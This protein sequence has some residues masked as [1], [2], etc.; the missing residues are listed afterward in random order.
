ME[1]GAGQ[2]VFMPGKLGPLT[3]R[4]R[5]IK[6]ATYE[7]MSPGGVPSDALVAHHR[8][9]AAGGTAMTTVAYCA[10]SPDARTFGE[11]M[12]IHEGI[13]P[14]LRTLT[15]AVHREGAAA[16]LQLAHCGF[17]TK[18][19][20]RTV[21]HALGPSVTL[22]AYGLFKGLGLV[23]PMTESDMAL[24]SED[25]ARAALLAVE[26][27]FDAVELHLGHGYLLSQFL[28]P[29]TNRRRDAWGG[30]LE[31]RL[32]LPVDVARRVHDRVGSRAAILA[33]VNLRDGFRGGLELADAVEI[34]RRLEV[35]GVDA[36]VLSGGFTS[37]TPFYLLRGGRPLR[38]MIAVEKSRIQKLAIALFGPLFMKKYPFTEMF[39]LDDARAVRGAV[40][41]PLVLLGGIVSRDNLETAMREGFDFVALGRAL[42]HDPYLVAKLAR[43]EVERSGCNHCNECV[44][45]MDRGGVRCVLD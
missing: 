3:L 13:L 20:E 27:G 36:L 21:P 42:I 32:R 25:F 43:G 6:T 29:A 31:N 28:S 16:S 9:I 5:V 24:V 11:Q 30:S 23:R 19:T 45:E 2:A 38:G 17:F 4:N 1:T 18:N 41:M 12:H 10:V 26:A 7:G 34:A 40:R 39:F 14:R 44:V 33:K 37:R 35:E 15:D 8:E 22:N